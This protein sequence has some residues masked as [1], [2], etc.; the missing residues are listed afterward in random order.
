MFARKTVFV[1]GAGA[2]YEFGLP[3]GEGLKDIIIR[4]LPNSRAG[5]G[6]DSL[7]QTLLSTSRNEI[8]Q[9][10]AVCAMLQQGLPLSTS[11]DRYLDVHED[12]TRLLE[13]GKIAIAYNIIL[14]EKQ[15]KLWGG[16]PQ[17]SFSIG[18][19]QNTWLPLLFRH[20][21]EDTRVTNLADIFNNVE[22]IVFNYDRC[23]EHFFYHA[24]MMFSGCE[25][26]IAAEIVSKVKIVHPYGRVGRLPWDS[27][28]GGEPKAGFGADDYSVADLLQISKQIRTFTEQIED[29]DETMSMVKAMINGANRVAF[30]GFSF[31]DQN[32]RYLTPLMTT[33]LSGGPIATVWGV[34]EPDV[35]LAHSSIKA[36]L[37]GSG[38]GQST[39]QDARMLNLTA[40]DFIT[41]WGNTLRR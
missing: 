36:M 28:N 39:Y 41:Q 17:K 31:L 14:A 11:I 23:I 32:M 13:V 22:F 6:T 8:D 9:L 16:H 35:E 34:S 29:E 15:S 12:N 4:S 20:M 18:K 25:K 2:S 7:H 33:R 19:I 1:V 27:S 30:I 24:L 3:V 37:A 21:Q 40:G 38:P 26:H 10:L 5:F